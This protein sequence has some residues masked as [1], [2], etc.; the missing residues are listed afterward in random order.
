MPVIRLPRPRGQPRRRRRLSTARSS[1]HPRP[2]STNPAWSRWVKTPPLSASLAAV[3]PVTGAVSDR[4]SRPAAGVIAVIARDASLRIE[5]S[6]PLYI[7]AR[8]L[9]GFACRPPS[10][11]CLAGCVR[12]VTTSDLFS[13]GALLAAAGPVRRYGPARGL[14]RPPLGRGRPHGPP[15]W[16]GHARIPP[17][18]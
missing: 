16:S 11:P 18:A 12:K 4:L 2:L 10:R 7:G 5:C 13:P 1:L 3:L 8:N 9:F 14:P 15:P 6:Y 17:T